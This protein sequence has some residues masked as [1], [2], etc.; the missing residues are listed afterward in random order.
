MTTVTT[1]VDLTGLSSL[2]RKLHEAL[3][4]SGQNGD[5]SV[6]VKDETR[7]LAME[8]A[9]VPN[10]KQRLKLQRAIKR[11]IGSVF[12]AMPKDPL[13]GKARHGHEMEW[14]VAGP[15][16]LFGA[17]PS[18]ILTGQ[19]S[20]AVLAAGGV[21][22]LLYKLRGKLPEHKYT[23]TGSHGK[24]KVQIANRVIV[25]R[26]VLTRLFNS[27][28]KNIGKRDASFAETAKLLGETKIP[29]ST[30]AHFPTKHNITRAGELTNPESPAITFGSNAHGVRGLKPKVERAVKTRQL[31][32]SSRIRMILNGYARDGANIRHHAKETGEH[33]S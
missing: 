6:L 28:K 29:A 10:P 16:F 9:R 3:I 32:M 7:R 31:K 12:L 14:L 26:A 11:D 22:A 5:L 30:S 21:K 8:C 24:Q 33:E 18:Q 27:I 23:E 4:G 20:N 1:T 19:E 2:L 25:A 13:K 15:N 17:P